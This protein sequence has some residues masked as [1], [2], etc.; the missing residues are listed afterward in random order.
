MVIS[1]ITTST[2]IDI[3]DIDYIIDIKCVCMYVCV[4]IYIYI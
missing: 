4:Y 3:M 1:F 2:T